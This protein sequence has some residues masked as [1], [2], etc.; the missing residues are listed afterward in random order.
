VYRKTVIHKN[1]DV[2]QTFLVDGMVAGLWTL[3]GGR[4]ALEPFEPLPRTARRELEEE[5]AR[6]AAWLR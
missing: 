2:Q 4:I 1:G 6:L 5:A 3:D